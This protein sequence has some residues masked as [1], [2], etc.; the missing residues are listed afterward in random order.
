LTVRHFRSMPDPRFGC[1]AMPERI[2]V[3]MVLRLDGDPLAPA[4]PRDVTQAWLL[5]LEAVFT[6]DER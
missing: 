4:R 5:G 6:G 3:A 1:G 2:E